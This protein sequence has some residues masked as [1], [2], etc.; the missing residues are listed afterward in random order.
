MRETPPVTE[1]QAETR[2][3]CERTNGY[4]VKA[5]AHYYEWCPFCGHRTNTGDTHD[6]E[7]QLN[8]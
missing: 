4:S 1:P 3:T 5:G 8:N 7:I 6:I 2:I